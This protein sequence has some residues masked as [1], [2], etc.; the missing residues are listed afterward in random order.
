MQRESC[1]KRSETPDR[2]PTDRHVHPQSEN[3]AILPRSRVLLRFPRLAVIEV[4][5][6]PTSRWIALILARAYPPDRLPLAAVGDSSK[7]QLWSRRIRMPRMKEAF[8]NE[9]ALPH[10][11]FRQSEP[12]R[13]DIGPRHCSEIEAKRCRQ[14]AVCGQ[15]LTP[16]QAAARDVGCEGFDDAPV[17]GPSRSASVGIQSIHLSCCPL[18]VL[19]RNLLT[20]YT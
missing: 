20:P 19:L 9:G 14:R 2:S 12:P 17:E 1:T 5:R 7:D 16:L 3:E 6:D 13:L 4:G 18:I 8:R 11:S 15:L 10:A